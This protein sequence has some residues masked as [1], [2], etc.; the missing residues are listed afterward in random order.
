[1]KLITRIRN[2]LH[3]GYSSCYRCGGN[4]GWKE[5]V[6]HMTSESSGI[7]LFCE[8]C[9][10]VVTIGERWEALERW[11]ISCLANSGSLDP[12]EFDNIVNREFLE[13]P[14]GGDKS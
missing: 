4:W 5:G 13:W 14:R 3:P 8:E 9:D 6:T 1:M 11:K 10:P 12:I 2:A 7:F